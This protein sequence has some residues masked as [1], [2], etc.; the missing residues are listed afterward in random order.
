[1]KPDPIASTAYQA[2]SQA[3]FTLQKNENHWGS[4]ASAGNFSAFLWDPE[5]SATFLGSIQDTPLPSL[6]TYALAVTLPAVAPGNYTVQTIYFTN[7]PAAPP[8]F[9]QCSTGERARGGTMGTLPSLA[10]SSPC[11]DSLHL[12]SAGPSQAHTE[13]AVCCRDAGVLCNSV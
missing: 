3:V 13:G 8:A 4:A 2:G 6:S 1:M 12:L 10:L 7:N 11:P 9:Y 5:G